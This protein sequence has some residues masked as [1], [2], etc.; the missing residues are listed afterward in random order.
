MQ[1][2]LLSFFIKKPQNSCAMVGHE[3]DERRVLMPWGHMTCFGSQTRHEGKALVSHLPL[4]ITLGIPK[5]WLKKENPVSRL[6]MGVRIG[7]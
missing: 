1:H 2:R 4:S 6:N 7:A 3:Q 5:S